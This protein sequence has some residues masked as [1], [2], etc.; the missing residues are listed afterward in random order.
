MNFQYFR[1]TFVIGEIL[2][3]VEYCRYGNLQSYLIKNRKQFVN[4]VD[5][6][7]YINMHQ[8]VVEEHN[9]DKYFTK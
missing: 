7:G 3:I 8:L 9:D 2:V 4:L 5:K 6:L 1:I